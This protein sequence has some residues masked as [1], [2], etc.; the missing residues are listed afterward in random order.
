MSAVNEINPLHQS[1][2]A[3]QIPSGQWEMTSNSDK[4]PLQRNTAIQ[5]E[6]V[7]TLSKDRS[8]LMSSKKEPSA[9]VTPA[10]S[11]ALRDSFSVYA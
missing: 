9:P 4:T 6:D 8:F 2:T 1:I 7:V 3:R 10:E 5:P 11:K